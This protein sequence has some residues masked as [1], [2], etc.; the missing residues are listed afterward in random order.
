MY[1]RRWL[2][3]AGLL[4][5]MAIAVCVTAAGQVVPR[6]QLAGGYAWPPE[7][8]DQ[9]GGRVPDGLGAVVDPGAD[10][11]FP[12]A[13]HGK[14]LS[15][16]A[17]FTPPA[18]DGTSTLFVTAKIRPEWHIYSL[19]Q[20]AGGPVRSEIKLQGAEKPPQFQAVPP[21]ESRVIA[22]LDNMKVETHQGTVHWY[23]QIRLPPGDWTQRSIPGSLYAQACLGEQRCERPTD[24]KFEAHLVQQLPAEVAAAIR[25]AAPPAG[26]PPAATV[27][28]NAGDLLV[29]LFLAFLGGLILNL[30]PCALPVIS[31]KILSFLQQAGESRGRI[32]TL[33]VWYSAGVMS[34]FMVLAAMAATAQ[35]AWGEQFTLPW[36]KVSLTG[37]VFGMA[38][39]FLGVWEIPI[40]GFMGSARARQAAGQGGRQ[41]GVLQRHVRHAAGNAVQ[42]AASGTAV[43][44]PADPAAAGDLL[45]VRLDGPGHGLALP[46]RR[47]VSRVH[48]LPAQAGRNGWTP[49]SRSWR[50]CCWARWSTCSPRWP[51]CTSSPR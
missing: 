31:L 30:M 26:T 46:G 11:D 40:P 12:F 9:G 14:P 45:R 43:R 13:E 44:L 48:P 8:G 1:V 15:V 51:P 47:R 25:A 38:L 39:S 7:G 10:M 35:Q 22:E 33:N 49:S 4:G 32:F 5:G 41:R 23:A 20:P 2:L 6:Q 19:T 36:F 18:A 50:S 34:V 28:L 27:A 24:Y 42:R 29:K 17:G 21:P 3:L 16:R 37:L